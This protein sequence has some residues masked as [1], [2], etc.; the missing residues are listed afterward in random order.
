[1]SSDIGNSEQNLCGANNVNNQLI[2]NGTNGNLNNNNR[3]NSNRVRVALDYD[4]NEASSLGCIP[5]SEWFRYYKIARKHKRKKAAHVIFSLHCFD[6]LKEIKEA[7][8]NIEYIP[9]PSTAFVITRPKVREIIAADFR[10]RIVQTYLVQRVLPAM[11]RYLHPHSYAC[12]KGKG[13]LRAVQHLQEVIFEATQG[14]TRDAWL[15]KFDFKSF[16]M[17]ID[18]ELW[19]VRWCEWIDAN[20]EGDDKEILKYVS[21]VVYQSLPQCNCRIACHPA[22]FNLVPDH[23]QQLGKATFRGIPIGNVTSQE[24]VLFATTPFLYFIA[25]I[26]FGFSHYTDD[27]GGVTTDKEGFLAKRPII[28]DFAERECHFTLHPDKFYFQHYS[29]GMEMLG[30]RLKYGLILPSKRLMHNFAWKITVAIRRADGNRRYVLANKDRFMSVVNSC[31]G[32]LKHTASYNY[33]KRQLIRL[34]ESAW[35]EVFDFD[36]TNWLKVTIKDGY[37]KSDYYR[38]IAKQRKR[39]IFTNIKTLSA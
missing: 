39:K 9:S 25:C 15:Y 16:F 7:V 22:M 33:R 3:I 12:R 21:R 19:T 38:F 32:L 34:K 24:F 4:H 29:K 30:Y 2:F 31:C 26:V 11:E 23:K 36:E 37:R 8:N 18:T 27:N 28:A 1:M 14:Y 10:D 17:S 6:N 20:V 5:S 13:G 35:C